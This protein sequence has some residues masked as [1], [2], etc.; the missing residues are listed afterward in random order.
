MKFASRRRNTGSA[1]PAYLA[2]LVVVVAAIYAFAPRSH[3][4]APE[5][6]VHPNDLLV[7]GLARQGTRVLAV[8]EQGHILVADA[9][10]GPWHEAKIT[11]DH[12]A[13]LT[14]V[15]FIGDKTALAVGHDS[16]IL[17]STDA[18]ETCREGHCFGA[19]IY[20]PDGNVFAAVSVSIPA[21]RLGTR[22]N[23][24]HIVE[25]VKATASEISA[26]LRG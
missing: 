16:V 12:G 13:T 25:R 6:K 8:G 26:K 17:K 20:G 14:Q 18:G 11:P 15:A 2:T 7:N 5:T 9:P 19:P 22:E 3:P 10:E 4:P 23:Q 24:Q 1:W 21:V